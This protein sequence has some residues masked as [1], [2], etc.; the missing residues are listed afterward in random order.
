[1]REV[2]MTVNGQAIGGGESL[3]RGDRCTFALEGEHGARL[4][5]QAVDVHDA[6]AALGRVA[7][8]V[9]SGKAELLAKELDKHHSFIDSAAD[10]TPVHDHG[11]F[12]HRRRRCF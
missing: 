11:H 10:V 12:T 2:S 8:D 4:D 1:M 7:T 3:N 9:R 6:C 5:R